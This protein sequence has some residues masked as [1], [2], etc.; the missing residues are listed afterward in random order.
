MTMGTLKHGKAIAFSILATVV[1]VVSGCSEQTDEFEIRETESAFAYRSTSP[2]AGVLKKCV[3]VN[4]VAESC[5][6]NELPAIGDGVTTPTVEQVMDRV[7]VT[8]NWMG[9]RFEEVIRDAPD[10][11]LTLF[12]STTAILIG[13]K[14][15]PSFYTRL[16]GAIQLDP[17]YIW[18]TIDEKKSI[19]REEDFR[20]DFGK[21]LQFWF[22][23]RLANPDGSRQ[24]AYYSL[25]DD[26]ER[27]ID[28][29][30]IPLFRLL[31]HELMHATDFMPRHKIADLNPNV[32]IYESI[33]SIR[34]DWLSNSLQKTHPLTSDAMREFA[35]VRYRGEDATAIQQATNSTQMGALMSVDGAIKFY[36]Y[37]SQYED[38]AQLVEG[39]MMGHHFN[40]VTNIGFTQKPADENN[41]YF[42]ELLVSWGQRNRLGDPLVNVR[43]RAATELSVKMTPDLVNFLDN[44]VGEAESM[45]TQVHWCNNQ[46]TNA[47][48]ASGLQTRS[49]EPVDAHMTGEQFREMMRF[50]SIVHPDGFHHD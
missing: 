36:S 45:T 39:V 19:S 12:S 1:A 22:L 35:K 17:E 4:T 2:Y 47:V 44:E 31:F 43:A 33:D 30:K 38:L 21:D 9:V 16:N 34:E 50:D 41:Y 29:V 42:D 40:S 25:D 6:L 49:A 18:T 32:S 11:L 5:T 15:R 28:D 26:S 10:S 20:S 3:L 48:V 23:S 27:P 46:R 14:V 7:L 13:S 37:S 8:H 24:A